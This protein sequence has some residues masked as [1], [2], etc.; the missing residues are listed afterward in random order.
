MN[1]LKRLNIIAIASIAL[2]GA[3]A[4][5]A[6]AATDKEMDRARAVAAQVYLRYTNDKSDY[7]DGFKPQSVS[8][9]RAKVSGHSEDEANLQKFL[10]APVSNDYA[11]WG[12]EE[13]V[14]Y[15]SSD[16]F[17]GAGLSD[18]AADT[19]NRRIQ[20]RLNTMDVTPPSAQPEEQ[21]SQQEQPSENLNPE[22]TE[23]S[24][25]TPVDVTA[26]VTDTTKVE[27]TETVT[28]TDKGSSNLWIY[29][30]LLIVLIGVVIALVVYALKSMRNQNGGQPQVKDADD[31]ERD[32]YQPAPAPTPTRQRSS[33]YAP[34]SDSRYTRVIAAK[35]DEIDTLRRDLD[36]SRAHSEQLA[37]RLGALQLEVQRLTEENAALKG[38]QMPPT[39]VPAPAPGA[40]RGYNLERETPIAPVT[41]A[42][43]PA[44]A[45]APRQPRYSAADE[46]V[47][48]APRS[49]E[50]V[51]FLG[52]V[53]RDNVFV[54]AD[55]QLV[56]GKTIYRLVTTNGVTGSFYV[57]PDP[58]IMGWVSLD[59]ETALGG[60]CSIVNPARLNS[61]SRVVTD[62]AGTAIF[63][64]GCW[65]VLR[66]ATVRLE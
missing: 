47:R 9:L 41:P 48:P 33:S 29:I 66:A 21:P 59:P 31:Y 30:V 61:F 46:P 63:E 6:S 42:A 3:T 36:D 4:A 35:D 8:E 15:W 55:K 16:F 43:A 1:R 2:L 49:N 27:E 32:S 13:L 54:R 11:G 62:A 52:R 53:N 39:V 37:A 17:S 45:P 28:E 20:A 34:E 64:D 51:V 22:M 18:K 12:K 10:S 58:V 14:K 60:G 26:P 24:A 40:P 5:P 7:L 38:R 44:P 19:R 23:I 50:R 56:N 65:K 25:P 57:E